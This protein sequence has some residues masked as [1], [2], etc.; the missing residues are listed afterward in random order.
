MRAAVQMRLKRIPLL[1]NP[2]EFGQRENLKAA[3][4]GQNRM[5]PVHEAV[6]AAEMVDHLASGPQIEMIRVAQNNLSPD[7]FQL[8]GG[9]GLDRGL[10]PHRHED[11]RLDVAVAGGQQSRA[12]LRR[13]VLVLKCKHRSIPC[14]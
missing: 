3:A 7:R 6:Q 13:S 4:V 8:L 9:H 1:G 2:G 11:G 12:G 5:V 14:P 10:S